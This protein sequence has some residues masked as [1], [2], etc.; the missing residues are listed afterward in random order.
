MHRM[1]VFERRLDAVPTPADPYSFLGQTS[2]LRG[3]PVNARPPLLPRDLLLQ[4]NDLIPKQQGHQ[5]LMLM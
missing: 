3:D 5:M 4:A 1:I 2:R